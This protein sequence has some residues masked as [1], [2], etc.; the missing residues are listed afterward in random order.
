MANKE[1]RQETVG[2]LN[3]EDSIRK[4][5]QVLKKFCMKQWEPALF[6]QQQN[7]ELYI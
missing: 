6:S 1:L 2:L 5:V 7:C 4:T 3:V